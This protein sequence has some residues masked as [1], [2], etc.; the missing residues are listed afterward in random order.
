MI[1]RKIARLFFIVTI[2]GII[3]SCNDKADDY[4]NEEKVSIYIAPEQA[5]AAVDALYQWGAPTFY[6]KSTPQDGPAAA[7]GGFLS[8]F[9]DNEAKAESKLCS[10]CQQLSIDATNIA[11]YLDNIWNQAYRAIDMA[12]EAIDN[13][14]YTQELTP[15]QQA[16]LTAEAS[17]FRAF[18]YF[19]LARAFGGV[20]LVKSAELPHTD[21]GMPRATLQEVYQLIVTDL[22][23]AIPN[24]K[25]TAFTDNNFRIS[26]TTAETM[27]ADVYLTMSGYPLQQNHY[28][29]AADVARRII[30]SG[31][32][33]LITHGPTEETSAYNIL[34]TTNS[35]VEYIYSYKVR[36]RKA[37]E[38]V[39]ALSL[40]KE[41][42]HWGVLKTGKTNNAYKPTQ[43][44]LNL[45]DA[46]Y[47]KRMHE[48]QFFHTFYRY[49]K[50]GRTVIQTF[51]HASYLWFDREAMQET[52]ISKK[53]ILIY[54]YAEVLLMAAETIAQS[55][56]VTTE[57]IGYLADVRSRAYAT[58]DRNEIISRL[59][60]LDKEKFIEEVWLER[61]REF[62]FEMK[63]W[64]DIQRTRKYPVR[65]EE[66]GKTSIVFKD[67]IGATNPWGSV[68][69]E[70]HLLLPISQN[71]RLANTQL[72]QNPGYN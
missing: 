25:D 57:A 41:A 68:F 70:K 7:V 6:G 30:N 14:P 3:G 71:K 9:F 34:R 64:T 60:E 61:I 13:I 51:P 4:G 12:N 37:D 19:Y 26:R 49:E 38:S 40:S 29:E 1:M 69:Q 10:H 48:Q 39:A 17:F 20:P 5:F 43:A 47:D 32:H 33:L 44:L 2:A 54:R 67:V 63:I 31:N 16:H 18:N 46:A 45:Y 56:G 55:E 22:Q 24:L 36:E 35:N 65:M 59:S 58:T 28:K 8:G 23:E 15:E 27:L 52:G 72:E 42:T 66:E 62:P 21:E 11:D 53:D 50:E